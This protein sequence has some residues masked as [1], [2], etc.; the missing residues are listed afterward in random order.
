MPRPTETDKERE[1]LFIERCRK[2]IGVLTFETEM[3]LRYGFISGATECGQVAYREG[4][5]TQR[6]AVLSALGAVPAGKA[7]NP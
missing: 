5:E 3:L 4:I 2:D 7:Y 1:D 6:H